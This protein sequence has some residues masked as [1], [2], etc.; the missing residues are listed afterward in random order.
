MMDYNYTDYIAY[1]YDRYY[2]H[3]FVKPY[4]WLTDIVNFKAI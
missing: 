4:N 2:R 3:G 1:W